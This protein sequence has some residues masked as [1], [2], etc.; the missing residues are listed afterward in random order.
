MAALDAEDGSIRWLGTYDTISI[1]PTMGPLPELRDTG[2][3][4]NVPM[5]VDG[6]LYVAPRDSHSL[7]AFDTGLRARAGAERQRAPQPGRI[8]QRFLNLSGKLRDLVGYRGGRLYFT[9]PGGVVAL[10]ISS[11]PTGGRFTLFPARGGAGRSVAVLGKAAMT[12]RGIAFT[13]R[14]H[15]QL[16]DYGLSRVQNLT[17]G[18]FPRSQYGKYPGNVCVRDGKVIVTSRDMISAF[19]PSQLT[20]EEF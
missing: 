11:I 8:L 16:I 19:A 6:V 3:G 15:L 14:T 9:G 4:A 17:R 12:D 10:D 5:L 7:Y 2:W 1:T 20:G 18:P 13:T